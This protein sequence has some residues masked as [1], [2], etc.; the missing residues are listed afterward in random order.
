MF[1]PKTK[2]G[3]SVNS[4]S[5][6][7][8]VAFYACAK[9]LGES[10]A[11]LPLGKFRRDKGGNVEEMT[12]D[13]VHRLVNSEPSELYTSF[14]F[15]STA[16]L[17]LCIDGNF[18]AEIIRNGIGRPS[19]LR[20]CED[21]AMCTPYL[22]KNGA[23]WY[24]LCHKEQLVRAAD[25]FHVKGLS[26]NGLK[27]KSP[28]QLFRENVGMGLA[29]TYAQS[30]LW[31]NGT[32]STGY[33]K[34]PSK[35]TPEQ[36]NNMRDMWGEKYAGTENAGKPMVLENGLEYIPLTLK[37]ADA[38]F[39]ETAKLSKEDMASIH[40]VP[41]HK[42]GLL[43]RSTNNNIEHQGLEFRTDTMLPIALNFEQEYNRKLLF[44]SEKGTTFFRHNMDGLLIAD[45][46]SRADFLTKMFNIGAYNSDEIRATNS[47]NP[48]PGGH[49]K[50]YFR[51]LNMVDISAP[52]PEVQGPQETQNN[53]ED[54]NASPNTDEQPA[55]AA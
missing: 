49:G 39:I 41:Q 7:T 24:K 45:S 14:T 53:Q 30:A 9:V 3:V 27:G 35:L 26:S 34:H 29:T 22:D 23:L 2:S 43:E 21:P 55:A 13:P 40:R 44:D 6:L 54:D 33:L 51:P 46:K 31:K 12:S 50:T 20:I 4:E 16:M 19:E 1:G 15:R 28:L 11:S 25:V 38:L 17:H 37:P 36:V 52:A 8:H 18:Y 48:I 47:M 5:I 42:I 10:L 32:L